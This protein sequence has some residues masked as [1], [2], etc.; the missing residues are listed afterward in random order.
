MRSTISIC[1]DLRADPRCRQA[2]DA[3]GIRRWCCRRMILSHVD[4]I[5]K[6]LAG[7]P[8]LSCEVGPGADWLLYTLAVARKFTEKLKAIKMR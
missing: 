3:L 4:L 6:L 8:L 7:E 2:L 1:S 5:E